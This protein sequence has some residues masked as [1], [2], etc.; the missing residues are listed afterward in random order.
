MSLLNYLGAKQATETIQNIRQDEL[1]SLDEQLDEDSLEL[2][3][4]KVVNDIHA[5]P[6]WYNFS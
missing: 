4:E 2:Y 3:W 5:D 6:E 1:F